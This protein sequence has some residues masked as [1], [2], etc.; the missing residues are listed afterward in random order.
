MQKKHLQH[1]FNEGLEQGRAEG[2]DMLLR[3]F[4]LNQILLKENRLDDLERAGTDENF[5]NELFEKY[6]L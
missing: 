4:R 1:T 5:R 2:R 3:F 6:Q